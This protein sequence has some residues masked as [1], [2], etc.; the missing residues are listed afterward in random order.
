MNICSV[1]LHH[2]TKK[3]NNFFF[4][5][6]V[7]NE[8]LC[9]LFSELVSSGSVEVPEPNPE[10]NPNLGL[11]LGLITAGSSAH[12]A[13]DI[14]ECAEVEPGHSRNSSNTSQLSK[15]SGYSSLNSQS[16]HSRQSSSGDSGHIRWVQTLNWTFAPIYLAFV[17]AYSGVG[18]WELDAFCLPSYE[19][20]CDLLRFPIAEFYITTRFSSRV[21]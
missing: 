5:W 21:P 11:T 19:K 10:T 4:R 13:N 17:K 3:N 14:E 8:N 9:A 16:Q 6:W 20:S 2:Y 18:V 1:S 15:A 7:L 12:I